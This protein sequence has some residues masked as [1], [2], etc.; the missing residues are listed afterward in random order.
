MNRTKLSENL[1]QLNETEVDIFTY[2]SG[3][4]IDWFNDLKNSDSY[5][6]DAV[7]LFQSYISDSTPH[8]FRKIY[9]KIVKGIYPP[10][11]FNDS[12]F[13]RHSNK[14]NILAKRINKLYV[15]DN[16]K[17]VLIILK[18]I[19]KRD[20]KDIIKSQDYSDELT[21]EEFLQD[22]EEKYINDVVSWICERDLKT[23]LMFCGYN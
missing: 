3:K 15:S 21:L 11:L 5:V 10:S 9:N 19:V 2:Y 7:N 23:I 16:R 22:L 6:E 18:A 13:D 17:D 8:P 4:S 14:F 1:S 20:F 12:V